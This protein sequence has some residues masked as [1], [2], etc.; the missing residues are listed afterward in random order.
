MQPRE[1]EDRELQLL[2]RYVSNFYHMLGLPAL[3]CKHGEVVAR[4]RTASVSEDFNLFFENI[5]LGIMR[6]NKKSMVGCIVEKLLYYGI[7][8]NEELDV[9]VFLGPIRTDGINFAQLRAKFTP[10]EYAFF[11]DD[12]TSYLTM[13]P[14]LNAV[15]F[16]GFCS[17]L[18]MFVNHRENDIALPA[19]EPESDSDI[20]MEELDYQ[21]KQVE[22]DSHQGN[23]YEAEKRILF[24]VKNGMMGQID[25]I[26]KNAPLNVDP[27]QNNTI[28]R[29]KDDIIMGVAIASREAMNAGVDSDL[30]LHMVEF[31]TD[32]AESC[33]SVDQ[34]RDLRYQALK[35][36]S[37]KVGQLSVKNVENPII[38]RIIHYIIKNVDKQITCKDISEVCHIN[39]SYMSTCFK[40]EMGMNV[41]DYINLQKVI[42]AKQ[43][44]KFSDASLVDI[45]C[46]LAFSS[47]AYFTKIF[48]DVVGMTPMEYRES[49]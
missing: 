22:Y 17:M 16:H 18:D 45:S 25:N 29:A 15:R 38:Y 3:V 10:E 14:V 46:A 2:I 31:F 49:R 41:V 5:F 1:Q 26:L 21:Q 37:E 13:L 11:K 33:Y 8:Y 34:L 32:R 24:F 9:A 6:D 42:R 40:K 27:T 20:Y 28:R 7:S 36:F 4:F 43:L 23:F 39:R 19:V 47:Q 12:V 35:Y 30:C 48:K 44:L